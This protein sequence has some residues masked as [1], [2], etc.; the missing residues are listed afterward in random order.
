M[1]FKVRDRHSL[2]IG[3]TRIVNDSGAA[4]YLVVPEAPPGI[5]VRVENRPYPRETD[6]VVQRSE[7]TTR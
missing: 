4:I 7:S 6:E 2:M 3:Q 5:H 1:K